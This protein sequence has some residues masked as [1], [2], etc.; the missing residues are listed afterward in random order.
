MDKKIPLI[1]KYRKSLADIL[2]KIH[3]TILKN[4]PRRTHV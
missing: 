3:L 2:R 4:H 1:A